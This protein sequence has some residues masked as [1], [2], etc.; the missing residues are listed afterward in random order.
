VWLDLSHHRRNLYRRKNI[1]D[2]VSSIRGR[3]T[4]LIGSRGS[5]AQQQISGTSRAT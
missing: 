4:Y 5:G 2:S 3:P 1:V